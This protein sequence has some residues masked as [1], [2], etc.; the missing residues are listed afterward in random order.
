M[1]KEAVIDHLQ[2]L[3]RLG[4]QYICARCSL[5]LLIGRVSDRGLLL[6]RVIRE[7]TCSF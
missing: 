1:Y 3:S 2:T 5:L 4:E 7:V 6:L